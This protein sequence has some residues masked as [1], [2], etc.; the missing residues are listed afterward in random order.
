MCFYK[1][2]FA[3]WSRGRAGHLYKDK[4]GAF[5]R[6]LKDIPIM[7]DMKFEKFVK[8]RVIAYLKSQ[9]RGAAA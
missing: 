4:Y 2:Q 8:S 6:G 3:G 1:M 5:P 9:K 7:P